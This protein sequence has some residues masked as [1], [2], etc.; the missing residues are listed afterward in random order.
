MFLLLTFAQKVRAMAFSGVILLPM[1]P[2]VKE[3]FDPLPCKT[4]G[5]CLG[6][7]R[8]EITC[9]IIACDTGIGG[10]DI[11]CDFD[12]VIY[13]ERYYHRCLCPSQ[14]DNDY[15]NGVLVSDSPDP[16]EIGFDVLCLPIDGCP[17]IEP[18]C[19][20]TT[21]TAGVGWTDFCRCK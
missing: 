9:E 18:I 10:N 12:T 6:P 4:L 17:A 2:G 13:G 8:Y 1:I 20:E 5:R 16:D 11:L 3:A 21:P 15:C 14:S 19:D 7:E